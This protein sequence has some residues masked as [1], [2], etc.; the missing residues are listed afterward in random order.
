MIVLF[1][2][3]SQVQEVILKEGFQPP[4]HL[5]LIKQK[6]MISNF[7]DK[8]EGFGNW[9]KLHLGDSLEQGKSN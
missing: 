1:S 2:T 6:S 9:H 3:D 7:L 8:N 4:N 5:S